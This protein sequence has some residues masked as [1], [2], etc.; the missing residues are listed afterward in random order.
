MEIFVGHIAFVVKLSVQLIV[1]NNESD[2]N[3]HRISSAQPIN[4]KFLEHL[5]SISRNMYTKLRLDPTHSFES[6]AIQTYM[7]L[8][9]N[10]VYLLKLILFE[11]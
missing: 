9:H 8:S 5:S 1:D 3:L 11:K 4:M 6:T 7:V 2:E 10:S